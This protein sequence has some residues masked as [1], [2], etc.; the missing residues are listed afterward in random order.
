VDRA[1]RCSECSGRI[2]RARCAEALSLRGGA[3]AAQ[4]R[5]GDEPLPG[6]TVADWRSGSTS[7]RPEGGA[8]GQ[9]LN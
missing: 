4:R 5:K 1:L 7:T 2:G 6:T 3:L 8:S 9:E